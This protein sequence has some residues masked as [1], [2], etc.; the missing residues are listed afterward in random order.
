MLS[1]LNNSLKLIRTEVHYTSEIEY[2]HF[3]PLPPIIFVK[4]L[5]EQKT[6]IHKVRHLGDETPDK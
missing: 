2:M 6:Q 1:L 5:K 3:Y 4:W